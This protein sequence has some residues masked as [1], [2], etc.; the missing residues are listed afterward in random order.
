V[1]DLRREAAIDAA[2][3]YLEQP[4]PLFTRI[5]VSYRHVPIAMRVRILR[6]LARLDRSESQFPAYP[7]E[8]SIDAGV[9]SGGYDRRRSA[10]LLTHDVDSEAELALIEPIRRLERDRT[11]VSSWG[12]VPRV[13]WPNEALARRLVD[14]DCEIY[15]HDIGHDGK[16]PYMDRE[17]MRRAFDEVASRH[18]WAGDLMLAF[19][20]GQALASVDLIDVVA[21]RFSIDM[22]IPDTEF[23]GPYGRTAGCGTVFPFVLRGLLEIPFTLPQDVYLRQVQRLSPDQVLAAWLSKL[24]YIKSVGGVAVLNVHPIWVSGRDRGMASSYEAFLDAIVA[25]D[26]LLPTTPSKLQGLLRRTATSTP[27]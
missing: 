6:L 17:S 8:R 12:F 14:E 9:V 18:P 22:S 4:A 2:M 11:L 25:D 15:W 10:V 1:V 26:Q 3:R 27:T 13:S 7:I 19:R 24:E 23:G 20:A 21:E 16:L 5:P